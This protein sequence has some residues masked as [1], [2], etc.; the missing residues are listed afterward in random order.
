MEAMT[1][2]F[3]IAALDEG[4]S[5]EHLG[6]ETFDIF[7]NET[8]CWKNVPTGVWN[9]S[10]GGYQVVKKWLSYREETVLGRQLTT[11]ESGEV[12]YVSEM[13][14]RIAAILLMGP[15]LDANYMAVKAACYPWPQSGGNAERHCASEERV[16]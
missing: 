6:A 5:M 9:Y 7:L 12:R 11:G 16:L 1:S 8:S 15:A 10:I 14:R 3:S 4:L 2:G 13:V